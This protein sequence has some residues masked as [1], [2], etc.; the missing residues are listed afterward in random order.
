MSAAEVLAK[1]DLL[2]PK[3]RGL[4]TPRVL[5]P[6][7]DGWV[8][9]EDEREAFKA[10][11]FQAMPLIVGGNADEGATL[12]AAWPMRTLDDLRALA[13][14]N[15]P[16]AVETVDGLYP[17][18]HEGEVRGRVAEM[19]AD[20]QFNYGVW[21]LARAMSART[22]QTWRYLFLR[23]RVGRLDGPNHGEEVSYVFNTL[24]LAPP[25]Q[26]VPAFDSVDAGV[27]EAMQAA[28]VR[29]AATGDPNGGSL[30]EWPAYRAT[31]DAHLE[32][33]DVIRAGSK[34]RLRQMDFLEGYFARETRAAKE[35]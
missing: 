32:F 35:G 5:R 27:A 25:G 17:A 2:V 18:A 10:G 1:T 15:F 24:G 34:W 9:R 16:Q 23:R 19:F 3:V 11:R 28:W 22:P 13:G 29:F 14:T 4:T 21:Q 6:I 30:P 20:T 33:G 26:Q 31:D 7:R 8:I 12:T